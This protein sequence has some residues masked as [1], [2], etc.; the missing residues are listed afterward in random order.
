MTLGT[1]KDPVELHGN[2]SAGEVIQY[3]VDDEV[4]IPINTILK[5]EDSRTASASTGTGDLFAGV[6]NSQK[7]ADDGETNL[8]AWTCGV[9]DFAASG[10]ISAGDTLI[11]AAPG[12]YVMASASLV[13]HNY[14]RIVGYALQDDAG[15]RVVARVNK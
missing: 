2:N 10:S 6:A 14:S 7:V 13:D 1:V 5:F 9:F 4:D 12:N 15:G 8:G 11:T 3:T